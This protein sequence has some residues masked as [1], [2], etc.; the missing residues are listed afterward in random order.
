[1]LIQNS[2][3]FPELFMEMDTEG[4]LTT[5]NFIDMNHLETQKYLWFYDMEWLT[6]EKIRNFECPDYQSERIVPFA[7]T[8]GGDLWGWHLDYL[9]T[10]PVVY[11]PHDDDEGVFYAESFEAALFR[12]ILEFASQNNFCMTGG[13]SWEM[14]IENAKT[15][16]KEWKKRYFKWFKKEWNLEIDN[17]LNL[18]MKFYKP[19]KSNG[20]YV[21]ITPEEADVLIDRY[22]KFDLLKQSF[23]WTI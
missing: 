1:M 16:L 22:L 20:F 6:V 17:L 21:L 10:L 18:E 13:K 5:E 14:T 15:L 23:V 11:C 8:G 3:D 9:P 19:N 4:C 7:K 12:H 2:F